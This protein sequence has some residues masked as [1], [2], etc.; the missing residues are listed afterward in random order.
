MGRAIKS[1]TDY[2]DG[3]LS[4]LKLILTDLPA[5]PG[6]ACVG[7]PEL[8]DPAH[9]AELPADVAYR[10]RAAAR[11]CH[12]CPVLDACRDWA[13]TQPADDGAVRAGVIPTPPAT[14]GRPRKKSA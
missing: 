4:L 5:L 11:L 13:T 6:A 9:R 7:R 3:S 2:D 8:F 10:H 1:K 14:P 12:A